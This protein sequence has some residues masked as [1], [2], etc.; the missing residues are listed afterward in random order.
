M[1]TFEYIQR[2]RYK[3]TKRGVRREGQGR[4]RERERG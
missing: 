2:D 1:H 3:E 4:E